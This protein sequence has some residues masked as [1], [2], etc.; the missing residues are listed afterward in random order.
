[1]TLLE[2][3]LSKPSVV[4][5]FISDKL[6]TA[7][8]G[9]YMFSFSTQK[10]HLFDCEHTALAV[11]KEE[12]DF[13]ALFLG[14]YTHWKEGELARSLSYDFVKKEGNYL[15]N[16]FDLSIDSYDQF[17]ADLMIEDKQTL[18]DADVNNEYY[19]SRG[20]I[21]KSFLERCKNAEYVYIN[22]IY[23]DDWS[24]TES[25]LRFYI[26]GS[27]YDIEIN[28]DHLQFSSYGYNHKTY[29]VECPNV[30]AKLKFEFLT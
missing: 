6:D 29:I 8:D 19:T 13:R 4:A 11:Q 3:K 1:M 14:F 21:T 18:F 7:S 24:E 5:D 17:V 22:D 27:T 25:C 30:D 10:L 28:K 20:G 2:P 16:Y 12:E 15:G 26:T 9:I 23:C